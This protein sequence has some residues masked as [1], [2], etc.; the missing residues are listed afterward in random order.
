MPAIASLKGFHRLVD[1]GNDDVA[2]QR[3]LIRCAARNQEEMNPDAAGDPK[4]TE[5]AGVLR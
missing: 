3:R 2:I 1:A 5:P 4:R